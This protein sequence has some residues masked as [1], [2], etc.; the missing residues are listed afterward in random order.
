M[1]V[2]VFRLKAFRYKLTEKIKFYV[3]IFK[4]CFFVVALFTPAHQSL[5]IACGNPYI[6]AKGMPLRAGKLQERTPLVGGKP[7]QLVL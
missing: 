5:Q 3:Q 6:L 1:D 4:G 7:P 2:Y